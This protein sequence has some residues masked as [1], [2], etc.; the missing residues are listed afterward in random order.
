MIIECTWYRSE[1]SLSH[2]HI[3]R[4]THIQPIHSSLSVVSLLPPTSVYS[5]PYSL[6]LIQ[7]PF[8]RSPVSLSLFKPPL[9]RFGFL[10]DHGKHP[11]IC[12]LIPPPH[13]AVDSPSISSSILL[14]LQ[15]FPLLLIPP[16]GPQG[17]DPLSCRT[18]NH[19]LSLLIYLSISLLTCHLLSL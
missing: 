11:S 10:A 12:K 6:S 3:R 18:G 16:S 13:I 9:L 4:H 1:L 14:P 17:S 2:T 19:Y 8:I 15:F 7:I 5:H